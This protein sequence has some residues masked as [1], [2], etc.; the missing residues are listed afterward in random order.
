MASSAGKEG[1]S[2]EDSPLNLIQSVEILD[3][4]NVI[5]YAVTP[6]GKW[7]L[8]QQ[9]G[10]LQKVVRRESTPPGACPRL[11]WLPCLCDVPQQGREKAERDTL[12]PV[13]TRP[14]CVTSSTPL[15]AGRTAGYEWCLRL[16][17]VFMFTENPQSAIS[18]PLILITP[19]S[20]G[21]HF[22]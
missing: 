9:A 17:R 11:P 12:S 16:L 7:K 13:S 4:T 19:H 15:P 22:G 8:L 1:H 18:D 3:Y 10:L 5:Y 6:S 2:L 21:N 20:L 14:G